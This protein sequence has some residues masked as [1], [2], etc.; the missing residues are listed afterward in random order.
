M[1]E[2]NSLCQPYNHTAFTPTC[3]TFISA[4]PAFSKASPW[5]PQV[6]HPELL[7]N[8]LGH[9]ALPRSHSDVCAKVVP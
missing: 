4:L 8:R 9:S 5:K 1:E 7:L 6:T 2:G 3:R